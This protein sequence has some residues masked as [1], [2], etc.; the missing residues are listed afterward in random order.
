MIIIS[1]ILSL[2]PLKLSDA[3]SI[4]KYANNKN[5]WINLTDMF[6]HPY[7]VND[8]VS[9]IN[10]QKDIKPPQVFAI[11]YKNIAVGTVG[12]SIS[13]ENKELCCDLGYWIGEEF[14]NKGIM[15]RVIKK[16]VKFGFKTYKSIDCISAYIFT[17]NKASVRVLEKI[18]FIKDNKLNK[19]ISKGGEKKKLYFYKILREKTD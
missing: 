10:S 3:E 4:A 6:P 13:S 19:S 5:V 17:Y 15:T 16:M 1:D 14:W 8:A 11:I 18:G 2:R 9:F 12:L 7:S